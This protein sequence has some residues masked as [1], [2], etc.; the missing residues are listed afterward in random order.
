[1]MT[2]IKRWGVVAMNAVHDRGDPMIRFRAMAW[3]LLAWGRLTAAEDRRLRSSLHASKARQSHIVL[4][5][6][7]KAGIP[8]GRAR[9]LVKTGAS[10]LSRLAAMGNRTMDVERFAHDEQFM[11]ALKDI[12]VAIHYEFWRPTFADR[13]PR[14]G[15][16]ASRSLSHHHPSAA[17][18]LPIVQQAVSEQSENLINLLCQAAPEAD[19]AY[20]RDKFIDK[21]L[22]ALA[23]IDYDEL[24][25]ANIGEATV[26]MLAIMA[27]ESLRTLTECR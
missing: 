18:L 20:L 10:S 27:S 17:A 26:E 9:D 6:L 12:R 25:S 2:L 15:R 5:L 8:R 13:G 3:D 4:A 7:I 22:E 14:R 21:E 1:M 19:H 23:W 24:S 11:D 16:R